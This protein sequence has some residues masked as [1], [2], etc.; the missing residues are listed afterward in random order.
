MCFKFQTLS[1]KVAD[2]VDEH[3]RP[4]H[5]RGLRA[6]L[7]SPRRLSQII[8][9]ILCQKIKKQKLLAFTKPRLL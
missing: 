4:D 2:E 5:Q 8:T 3:A 1:I 9:G 6:A 7:A